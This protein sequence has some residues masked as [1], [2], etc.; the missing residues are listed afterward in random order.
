[1][2]TYS[3]CIE[4]FYYNT[5]QNIVNSFKYSITIHLTYTCH[6]LNTFKL[7]IADN[8]YYSQLLRKIHFLHSAMI[9]NIYG[10]KLNGLHYKILY[11]FFNLFDG[12]IIQFYTFEKDIQ[13]LYIITLCNVF[14]CLF[15]S[16]CNHFFL[17][18]PFYNPSLLQHP[19]LKMWR[20]VEF[21]H[22][23]RLPAILV[24]AYVKTSWN[25]HKSKHT[26]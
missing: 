11:N 1:M 13:V 25:N 16:T 26:I 21:L 2:Y 24:F 12:R 5:L 17:F 22:P 18:P 8:I 4:I 14:S 9:L 3:Q 23:L 20:C 15:F 6:L 19:L 10:V 7:L